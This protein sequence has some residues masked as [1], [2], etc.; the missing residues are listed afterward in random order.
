M[1][2]DSLPRFSYRDEGIIPAVCEVRFTRQGG[3]TVVNQVTT[4]QWQ[5]TKTQ[6][7]SATPLP[8]PAGA[9]AP[10]RK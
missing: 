10:G 9:A 7:P 5:P 3:T 6:G 4:Y 8:L 2:D 1:G